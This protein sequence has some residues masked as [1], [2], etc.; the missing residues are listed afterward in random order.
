MRRQFLLLTLASAPLALVPHAGSYA[1]TLALLFIAMFVT[2][3]FIIG[4][5][6]YATSN[7]STGHA[8]LI[9]GLGAGSWSAVVGAAMPGMGR[10]FDLHR[11]GTAFFLAALFPVAGYA[12]WRML[13]A[14]PTA[15]PAPPRLQAQRGP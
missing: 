8:G 14:R 5:V 6:A 13:S 10:L 7:Y 2:A 12:I 9:A 11:Y 4:A 3:G 1:L 15:L